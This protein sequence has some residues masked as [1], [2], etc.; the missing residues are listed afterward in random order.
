MAPL[1]EDP[2]TP[3]TTKMSIDEAVNIVGSGPAQ[4]LLFLITGMTYLSDAVEVAFLS[5]ASEQLKCEWGLTNSEESMIASV[6]FVGIGVG[7]PCWGLFADMRGRRQAF[8]CST[9][10]IA[11]CG[12]LTAVTQNY[13]QLLGIRCL[14]GFGVAGCPIAFDVL[15]EACDVDTRGR[16]T[17]VLNYW[18]TGGCLYVNLC[19]WFFLHSYGWRCLALL[20]SLPPFT[21][22]ILALWLLP[23]SPRWLVCQNRMDEAVEIMNSWANKNGVKGC[24][25]TALEEEDEGEAGCMEVWQDR[26]IRKDYWLLSLIWPCFTLTYWGIIMLLPRLFQK[27][28]TDSGQNSTGTSI[29]ELGNVPQRCE[30][31]FEFKNLAISCIAEAIGVLWA[32]LAVNRA[33]RRCVQSFGYAMCGVAALFLQFPQLGWGVLTGITAVGRNGIMA[34]CCCTWV[35]TPELFPTRLRTTAH[36]LLNAKGRIGSVFAPFIIQDD[37]SPLARSLILAAVSFI[38]AGAALCLTETSGKAIGRANASDSEES[39]DDSDDSSSNGND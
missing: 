25:I 18:W 19:A 37:F 30:L 22:L 28:D 38:A 1:M 12:A 35:Q 24:P 9:A 36:G 3:I 13:W 8:I 33:G 21:S 31:E 5:F 2:K 14:T 29:A 27:H 17:M 32:S 11:V 10:M 39:L 23:E 16:Y 20:A 4:L 7:S 34:A 6:V 26:S 15:A